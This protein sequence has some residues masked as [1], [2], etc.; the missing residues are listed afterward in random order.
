MNIYT[1][2]KASA[3]YSMSIK[4]QILKQVDHEIYH[5]DF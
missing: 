4:L 3:A 2:V 1:A 5:G